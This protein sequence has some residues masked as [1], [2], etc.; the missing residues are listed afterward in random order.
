[1]TPKKPP[2]GPPADAPGFEESLKR[3]EGVV[4]RLEGDEATL[5]D[6]IRLY[7]EGMGLYRRC[8]G[9]LDEAEQKV[10]KLEVA[11]R[12]EGGDDADGEEGGGA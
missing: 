10:K 5:E 3:L 7:E 8:R 2:A 9:L 6:S 11:L 4:S 12:E 1:M